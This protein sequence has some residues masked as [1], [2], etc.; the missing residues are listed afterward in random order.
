MSRFYDVLKEAN[1]SRETPEA[2]PVAAEWAMLGMNA[3]E[4]P[5][6]PESEERPE[7]AVMPPEHPAAAAG[8]AWNSTAEEVLDSFAA[9]QNSFAP[10][11]NGPIVTSA[12]ITL[13]QKA[14]LIPHAVDA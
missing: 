1:R 4:P 3:T 14:R 9:P 13:D 12:K 6:V 5:P 11:K 10:P 7:I 2:D 8:A